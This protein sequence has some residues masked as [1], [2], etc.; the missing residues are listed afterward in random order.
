MR[1]DVN[2]HFVLFCYLP[3]YK[4]GRLRPAGREAEL[5]AHSPHVSMHASWSAVVVRPLTIIPG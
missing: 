4:R 1:G 5:R 3:D 2:H